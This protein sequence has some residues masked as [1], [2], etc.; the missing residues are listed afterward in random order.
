[1]AAPREVVVLVPARVAGGT[2][3]AAGHEAGLG[4]VSRAEDDPAHHGNEAG[5]SADAAD[6][7][8]G[9]FVVEEAQVVYPI[10]ADGQ[11]E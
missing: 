5:Y 7:V 3:G 9:E 11:E 10:E 2:A 1:M 6:R 8:Q 4:F